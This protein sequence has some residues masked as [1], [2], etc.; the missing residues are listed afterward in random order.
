LFLTK[1]T[2]EEADRVKA[3]D[4]HTLKKVLER[5]EHALLERLLVVK[6]GVQYIQGA[7]SFCSKLRTMVDTSLITHKD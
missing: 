1:T 2:K 4:I 7:A 3:G 5:E 6:D